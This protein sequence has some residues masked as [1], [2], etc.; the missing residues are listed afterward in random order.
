LEVPPGSTRRRVLAGERADA[1]MIVDLA[2]PPKNLRR[3]GGGQG[4]KRK[5]Q[6]VI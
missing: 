6:W 3:I 1:A 4:L 2:H 5:A